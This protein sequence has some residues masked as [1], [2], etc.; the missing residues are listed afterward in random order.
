M[1]RLLFALLVLLL[2]ATPQHADAATCKHQALSQ[3]AGLF[4][5]SKPGGG[6]DL[7]DCKRDDCT[8][9]CCLPFSTGASPG[10]GSGENTNKPPQVFVP[11]PVPPTPAPVENPVAPVTPTPTPTEPPVVVVVTKD[12]V[13]VVVDDPKTPTPPTPT[14]AGI[15]PCAADGGYESTAAN[16]VATRPCNTKKGE[17]GPGFTRA[18]S[19]GGLW[20]PATGSCTKST[21]GT[22]G[23]DGNATGDGDGKGDGKGKGEGEGETTPTGKPG[24]TVKTTAKLLCSSHTCVSNL[25]KKTHAAAMLCTSTCDDG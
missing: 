17:T 18:C 4:T 2:L 20:Q 24:E 22:N 10:G 1:W 25:V 7:H 9:V 15:P 6:D 5:C 12:P 8:G 3:G 23:G 13:V 21:T 19:K 16:G 14:P 11:T